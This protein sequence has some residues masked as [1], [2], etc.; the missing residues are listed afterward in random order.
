MK[1]YKV[2][3]TE[4]LKKIVEVDAE[5][6]TDANMIASINDM[7]AKEGYILDSADYIEQTEFK[8]LL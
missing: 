1:K 8:V 3:I 6:E 2:E 5:N 4:T 7:E